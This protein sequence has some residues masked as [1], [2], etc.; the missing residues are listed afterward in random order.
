[1]EEESPPPLVPAVGVAVFDE[2]DR[3]VLVRREDTPWRLPGGRLRPRESCVDCARRECREELGHEIDIES[4]LGVGTSP[5]ER[6]YNYPDGRSAQF[7]GVVLRGRL[8]PEVAQPEDVPDYKGLCDIGRF[9]IRDLPDDI[10]SYDLP[11]IRYALS[12][13][14]EPFFN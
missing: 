11:S 2:L 10:V 14:K 1:M 5:G 4:L 8:G 6:T 7:V 9:T 3:L 12:G 13:T